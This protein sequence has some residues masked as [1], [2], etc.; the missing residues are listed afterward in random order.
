MTTMVLP[1]STVPTAEGDAFALLAQLPGGFILVEMGRSWADAADSLAPQLKGEVTCDAQLVTVG[2]RHGWAVATPSEHQLLECA[3]I[4]VGFAADLMPEGTAILQFCSAW[5]E[6]FRLRLWEQVPAELSVRALR[7]KGKQAREESISLLGQAGMEFGLALYEDPRA[8]DAIW[9]GEKYPMTGI[10]VLADEDP[11]LKP[12]FQ[13]FGVPPPVV[14]RIVDSRPFTPRLEDFVV[15]TAA[16]QL[17]INVTTG[18]PN[19]FPL[20]RGAT[21]ELMQEAPKGATKKK[22]KAKSKVKVK[23]R[24]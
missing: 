11:Y 20:G 17:L 2:R 5:I 16:M 7:R 9:S 4:A 6:F 8:F 23:K 15:A 22:P 19:S 14:T 3:A 10:S 1:L 13:P 12:A 21:L 18:E 24:K